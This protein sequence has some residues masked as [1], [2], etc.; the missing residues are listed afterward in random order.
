MAER[1]AAEL[2]EALAVPFR[3]GTDLAGGHPGRHRHG[4]YR[5]Q[6]AR[7]VLYD[8]GAAVAGAAATRVGPCSTSRCGRR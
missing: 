6:H 7:D 4:R 8:A 2:T 3:I 1:R 5:H